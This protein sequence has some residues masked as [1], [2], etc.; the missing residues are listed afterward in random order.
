[1]ENKNL[2]EGVEEFT[3]NVYYIEEL[4]TLVDVGEGKEVW[5][6]IQELDKVETVLITH[7]HHDHVRNLEKVVKEFQPEVYGF[8]DQQVSTKFEKL[9][10]GD[11]INLNGTDFKAIHTPGHKNDHLCFYNSEEGILFSGDLIFSE[12][13]FGRTDLAEGDRDTLIESIEKVIRETQVKAFYPGHDETVEN[14]ADEW[15]E[16]SL[17]NAQKREKKYN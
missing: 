9:A 17:E 4:D 6:K 15:I 5:E 13:S 10:D 3:A 7:T 12:G 2:S 8:K 1:M 14:N 11:K 16:K